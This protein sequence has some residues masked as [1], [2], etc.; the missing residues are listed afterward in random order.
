MTHVIV[1]TV[2]GDHID[3]HMVAQSTVATLKKTLAQRVKVPVECQGL[4]IGTDML[5]D[6]D[7]LSAYCR[8]DTESPTNAPGQVSPITMIVA[9]DRSRICYCKKPNLG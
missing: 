2:A 3:L 6:N 4:A 1:Q 7:P 5:E 9:L 8:L